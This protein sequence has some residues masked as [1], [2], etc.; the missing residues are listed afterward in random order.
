MMLTPE[1]AQEL[2]KEWRGRADVFK[3]RWASDYARGNE[4]AYRACADKLEGV[5][6]ESEGDDDLSP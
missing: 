5:I 2:V 1:K 3:K 6:A 4:E